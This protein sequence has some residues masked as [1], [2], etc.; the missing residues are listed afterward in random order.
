MASKPYRGHFEAEVHD[1]IGC[2][3]FCILRFRFSNLEFLIHVVFRSY[4]QIK[5]TRLIECIITMEF[6]YSLSR[7]DLIK[8][9]N[10][11]T[12]HVSIKIE[13]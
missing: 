3:A 4:I 6:V 5:L 11:I 2:S 13:S 10:L 8:L 12:K 7:M 1:L 9:A